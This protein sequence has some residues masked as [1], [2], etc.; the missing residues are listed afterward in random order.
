MASIIENNN[1]S[2][3]LLPLDDSDFS[4]KTF[5]N[6]FFVKRRKNDHFYHYGKNYAWMEFGYLIVVQKVL[7]THTLH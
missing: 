3:E 5:W 7:I 1:N 6:D 4:K 2:D